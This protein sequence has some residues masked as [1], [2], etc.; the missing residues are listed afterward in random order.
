MSVCHRF[1]PVKYN[2]CAK[3]VFIFSILSSL[4][5]CNS[6]FTSQYCSETGSLETIRDHFEVNFAF[7][8]VGAP[9]NDQWPVW[10]ENSTSAKREDCVVI[11]ICTTNLT[12]NPFRCS[13]DISLSLI[14]SVLDH[15]VQRLSRR[16]RF[17]PF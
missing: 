16:G 11:A 5:V 7:W 12:P 2:L 14:D 9:L 4:I 13:S 3:K 8:E 1:F 15:Y 10:I 6:C 17:G